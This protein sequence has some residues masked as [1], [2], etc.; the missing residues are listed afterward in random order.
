MVSGYHSHYEGGLNFSC[1]TNNSKYDKLLSCPRHL[2]THISTAE[3]KSRGSQMMTPA[4]NECPAGWTRA[5]HGYLMSSLHSGEHS[6]EFVCIDADKEVPPGHKSGSDG[7][8]L[9][10][11]AGQCAALPCC[12]PYIINYELTCVVCTK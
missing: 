10:V 3:V 11:V 9:Y 5:H 7:A 6:T 12:K 4:S 2:T 1:L 8:Q